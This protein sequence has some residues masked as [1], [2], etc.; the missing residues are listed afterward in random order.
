MTLS[1]VIGEW[2]KAAGLRNGI[3]PRVDCV[4]GPQIPGG[5]ETSNEWSSSYSYWADFCEATGLGGLFY[6]K[7]VGL[8]R[9]H[10]GIVRLD[11]HHAGAVRAAIARYMKRHPGAV[12]HWD[13]HTPLAQLHWLLFWFEWALAHCDV[14]AIGNA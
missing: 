1:I 5:D 6:D 13:D 11:E 9:A 12:P 10:P 7:S 8:L 14:P 3:V 4:S 2:V